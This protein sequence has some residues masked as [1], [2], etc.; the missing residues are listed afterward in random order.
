MTDYYLSFG[1]GLQLLSESHYIRELQQYGMTKRGFRAL[2]KALKVP[3]IR[4]PNGTWAIERLTFL[5][6]LRAITSLGQD[7]FLMPG[8]DL[9]AAGQTR[10]RATELNED[11]FRENMEVYLSELLAA[12]KLNDGQITKQI[13]QTAHSAADLL[14]RTTLRV[15]PPEDPL[16][17]A[18]RRELKPCH[19]PLMNPEN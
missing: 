5:L 14:A 16:V 7:D 9:K 10:G 3:R 11:V 2:C 8:C 12:R 15:G 17:A 13:R 6:A 4:M 18:A 1:S 19:T